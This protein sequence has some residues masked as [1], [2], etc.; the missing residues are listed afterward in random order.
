VVYSRRCRSL[1]R[2]IQG[3]KQS[4]DYTNK[5]NTIAI[6][7]DGSRVLGLGNIGPEAGLP[8]MERKSILF[9]HFGGVDAFPIMLKNQDE[10]KFIETVKKYISKIWRNKP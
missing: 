7:S 9:K 2:N 8:V 4:Y 6:M 1:H 10:D 3:E 5:G